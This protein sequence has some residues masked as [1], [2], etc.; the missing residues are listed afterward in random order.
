MKIGIAGPISTECVAHLLHGP[1]PVT[2][3]D[4][5]VRVLRFMPNLY[6]IGRYL[7]ASVIPSRNEN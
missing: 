4:S 6:R 1:I 5:P 7:M 2:A 3:H